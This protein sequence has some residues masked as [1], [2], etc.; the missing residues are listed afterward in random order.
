MTSLGCRRSAFRIPVRLGAPRCT[1]L[2]SYRS[3]PSFL[4]E[5]TMTDQLTRGSPTHIE[6]FEPAT[7]RRSHGSARSAPR[8]RRTGRSTRP[9]SS[10]TGTATTRPTSR[11]SRS[12]APAA[13]TRCC[14]RPSGV[15]RSPRRA[16]PSAERA[17]VRGR[18][19]YRG[20]SVLNREVTEPSPWSTEQLDLDAY[21][22]RI[23]ASPA[24]PSRAALDALHEAHVRSFTFDN[25]DV[26]LDQHPGVRAR[27]RA[28]EV[29]G[30]RAGRLLLRAHGAVLGR[31][32][33]ARLRRRATAWAAS[34]TR[35]PRRG[36]TASSS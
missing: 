15:A 28:G 34:V 24:P 32:G 9:T 4:K 2:P 31:P 22:A 26:L 19:A 23:G 3:A 35:R 21:L 6:A 10:R 27:R 7:A 14:C 16:A 33:T 25:I 18:P 12:C 11:R 36:R 8:R 17:P 30:P 29:R 13:A 5:P 20:S 1:S